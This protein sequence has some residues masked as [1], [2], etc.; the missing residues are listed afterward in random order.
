MV[1][2]EVVPDVVADVELVTDV[3]NEVEVDGDV[4][5]EE[6]VL[7]E[8]E[9]VVEVLVVDRVESVGCPIGHSVKPSSHF[10]FVILSPFPVGSSSTTS[11][12]TVIPS[13]DPLHSPVPSSQRDVQIAG[14]GIVD[15]VAVVVPGQSEPSP[16]HTPSSDGS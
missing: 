7:P 4:V 8:V 13:S 11:R 1:V 12:Q 14:T 3:V 5:G 15:D 6:V 2:A 16:L 9:G 10:P